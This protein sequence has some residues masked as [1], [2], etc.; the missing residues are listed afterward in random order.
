MVL[1]VVDT[2]RLI[3]NKGL[4]E[5]EL[6]KENVKRLIYA[7]REGGREV[8]Y[9]RHEDEEMARGTEGFEIYD[10][11]APVKD[12]RIFDKRANSAFK[13][14]GLSEYLREKGETEIMV[15]GLQTD[16]CIDAT[17]KCG[18]E[19][20]FKIIVPEYANSTFDNEFMT[21]EKTYRYYNDFMWNGRYAKCVC[22][23][24]AQ[25]MLK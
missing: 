8:I 11:F 20:G 15:V 4:H 13:D 23:K 14:T 22:M 18:F 16:Y 1:L 2:Q 6:F 21:A 19:H 5:F 7:A 24:E 3:T 17:V 12:E 25:E 9:V 10:E